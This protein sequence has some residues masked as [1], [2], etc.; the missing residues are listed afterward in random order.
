MIYRSLVAKNNRSYHIE[1]DASEMI[2]KILL[3]SLEKE[4]F[5]IVN[6]KQLKSEDCDRETI[7]YFAGI[8]K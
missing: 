1:L 3:D 8:I 5:V 2:V 6:L 7:N 4:G